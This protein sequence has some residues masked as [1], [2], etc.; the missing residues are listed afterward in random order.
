MSKITACVDGR[1]MSLAQGSGIATYGRNLVTTLSKSGVETQVLYGPQ[2]PISREQLLN[3]IALIGPESNGGK[4]TALKRI[5]RT[6]RARWGL[7]AYPVR[8]GR[9][10]WP[11]DG[12]APAPADAYWA[13]QDLYRTAHRSFVKS[14]R[15]TP[16]HFK[17]DDYVA[18]PDVCHWTAAMPLRGQ[19]A[20]NI[21]TMHDLIPLLLPH[22]S[23]SNKE[24][25]LAI[26][27]AI[28]EHADHII[29]GS[30]SAREDI[31]R[32][33]DVQPEKITNTYHAVDLPPGH[34]ERSDE[35]IARELEGAFG[36]GWKGYFLHYGTIE[37]RKNLG[38]TVE[39]YL[40]SGTDTPLVIAG[41]DGWLF[42]PEVALLN[43]VREGTGS[44]A[45]RIIKL[46][47]LPAGVLASLVRGAK[48]LLFPS[49]YEGFGLPVLEAMS[50]GTAVLTS[51][52]GSLPEV[53]G[54]AAVLV[55]PY[56]VDELRAGIAALDQDT[57]MREELVRLGT[58]QSAKFSPSAYQARVGALYEKLGLT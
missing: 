57:S 18:S 2:T 54:G 15:L 51:T 8:P 28:A 35:D 42:K 11:R 39:A 25:Y 16:V 56:N 21:Y 27:R 22:L 30:E 49:L 58:F 50:M 34:M 43:Q 10:I 38:R 33:L 36:L 14:G 48:A 37:P 3:E 24:H 45:K 12:G 31:V 47:Y 7:P 19:G 53:A 23:L 1:D 29:V 46:G 6:A 5:V 55:D 44:G 9:V 40:A 52:A 4:P 13:S 32:L 20:V 41:G 26:C 17:S